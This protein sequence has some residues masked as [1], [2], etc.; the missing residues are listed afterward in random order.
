MRQLVE[1]IRQVPTLRAAGLIN[2]LERSGRTMASALLLAALLLAS[3][4]CLVGAVEVSDAVNNVDVAD[5]VDILRCCR[6]GE[7]LDKPENSESEAR[8]VPTKEPFEPLIYSP[9]TLGYLSGRPS[10]WRL[11][12]GARPT[13]HESRALR[14]VPHSQYNPFVLF[15]SGTVVLEYGSGMTLL[16]DEFCLG[17]KTLLACVPKRNESHQAAATMRPKLRKCCGENAAYEK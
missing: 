3:T 2:V 13:C 7:D 11:R 5:I 9:E 12:A 14:Y 8:C 16:P 17:T 15:D 10:A 1:L 4:S 6:D